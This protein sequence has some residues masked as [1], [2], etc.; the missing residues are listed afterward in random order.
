M[1][2]IYEQ[3]TGKLTLNGEFVGLGYSGRGSGKNNPQMES[4]KDVGPI[5]CGWYT[6]EGPF[7]SETK[8]PVVFHLFPDSE[9]EMYNR[10]SFE[11]HGDSIA[12]PGWASDGCIIMGRSVRVQIGA[13]LH[14]VNRLQV[15]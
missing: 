14:E 13:D 5:P 11:I 1:N 15:V 7:T 6:I 3:T 8:G 10:D 12:N 4:S 9:N 2:Y